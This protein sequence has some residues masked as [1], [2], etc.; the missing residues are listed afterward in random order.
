MK[1]KQTGLMLLALVLST[2]LQLPVKAQEQVFSQ[3]PSVTVTLHLAETDELP[4]TDRDFRLIPVDP[5]VTPEQDAEAAA[6]QARELEAAWLEDPDK[7]PEISP[8]QQTRDTVVFQGL[9]PGLYLVSE[10]TPGNYRPYEP[11]LIMAGENTSI[12]MSIK[13]FLPTIV[14]RKTDEQGKAITNKPFAFGVFSDAECTDK[15][16]SLTAELTKGQVKYISDRYQTVYIKEVKAPSG[17]QLSDQILK[18]EFNQEGIFVDGQKQAPADGFAT[19]E[20]S[21]VNKPDG[22][23]PPEEPGHPDEPASPD[24]PG[25]PRQ[26]NT[27]SKARTSASSGVK[28][29]TIAAGLALT[30]LFGLVLLRR[31]EEEK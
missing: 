20:I 14:I 6:I 11:V 10:G 24:K 16:K 29:L 8:S 13:R 25:T 23:N 28:G 26:T 12:D 21:Y 4:V 17:Y 15:V 3:T 30:G 2:L 18:V 19:F 1:W 27:P 5:E 9:E 22:E 7:D 31:N